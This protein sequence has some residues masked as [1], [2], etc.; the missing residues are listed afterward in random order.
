MEEFNDDFYPLALLMDELKHDD[1]SNRVEAMQKLDSIAIALGPERTLHELLPFL[2]DVAQDDEEEVFAV[3]AEKLGDFV[4]LVGG[5]QN[6]EPLIH[7]LAIL[8]AMEEPIVRDTAVESLN[9]IAP[10]LTDDE[11][12]SLFLELI[13]SLSQGDWFSKKVAS[14]GLYKSVI[15]RVDAPLRRELLMLY[16][17]LVSDDSPMVRR[18]AAKHLPAIIDKLTEYS[19]EN[20]ASSKKVDDNDLE[21]IS[22]M[23]HHLINDAQDS[24]KLLSIDV[25]VAILE[26]FYFI[27]DTSHNSDCLVSALKLIKDDSW[28]VRYAAADKF[29]NIANNFKESE[30]DLLRLIDPFIGLMKDNEGEVR[31]AIAKQLPDFC[32]LLRDPSIIESKI[33][34]VVDE[35]SQDPHENVRASLAST[36]TGLSP[37]LSKQSTTEKLLPIFLAMLKDEFPD[38]RL[39]I[40]SNLSVVNETIGIQLLSTNLLPAI[41][42]LAQDGKWRVRLAIIE[43]IPKLATQ[44]G[45]EF[46]N[47]ELLTLCTSWLW[48][49]VFAVRDAAVNNLKDLTTIFGS[50]WAEVSIITHLLNIRDEKIGD[51]DVDKEPVNFSSFIIRITCLFAITKLTPE[52]EPS[53]ITKKILPFIHSLIADP[54]PNLR[55]NV[56]KSYLVAAEALA[57]SDYAEKNKVIET[58]IVPNVNVLVNDSDVDVRYYGQKSLDSIKELTA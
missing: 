55:F 13:R 29:S 23:F 37:I 18:S 47:K 6:A 53:V 50:Q 17:S 21:I 46:F 16:N 3:L 44:L 49:P 14:C 28:R 51:E 8:G 32:K 36:V 5:H 35:L 24:V 33:I 34:P 10:E 52:L 7:I 42:E 57:K 26:Y 31:K 41:T 27:Q 56:A 1:V 58:E 40:I 54:V 43:Y 15:V 4:P 11:L 30:A 25:L 22:K 19:K 2:N 48:D 12:N 38:V 39:N 9:K 20:P 45:V